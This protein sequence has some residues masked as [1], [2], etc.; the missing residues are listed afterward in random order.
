MTPVVAFTV[1]TLAILRSPWFSWTGDYLSDLGIQST[2]HI[3]FNSGLIVSGA[4]L[5]VFAFG[6][7][8]STLSSQSRG[9]T[10]TL[11]LILDGFALSAIGIFP[12]KGDATHI[13]ILHIL[14]A[15]AFFTLIPASLSFIG[16]AKLRSSERALGWLTITVAALTGAVMVVLWPVV[17]VCTGWEGGAISQ[18]I[19]LPPMA[20][21][22]IV[23]GIKLLAKP[24]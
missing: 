21:W 6:L 11:L 19:A 22:S 23:F 14:A 18:T 2:S 3:L 10:G 24:E 1:I 7:R 8:G 15:A 20:V 5:I 4:L 17:P 16:I 12:L 13:L 9:R